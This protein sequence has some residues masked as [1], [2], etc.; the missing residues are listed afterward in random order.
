MPKAAET[1]DSMDGY[2]VYDEDKTLFPHFPL[3]QIFVQNLCW[4]QISTPCMI[5]HVIPFPKFVFLYIF[6]MFHFIQIN[7]KCA[8]F[9]N[10]AGTFS[11]DSVL[12]DLFIKQ[13]S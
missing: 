8:G 5:P 7:N 1:V 13:D 11:A 3:K 10:L 2:N 4:S 12:G 6:R 9:G